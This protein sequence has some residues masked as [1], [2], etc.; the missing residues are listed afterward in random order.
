MPSA[1]QPTVQQ[2]FPL[3]SPTEA[4][5]VS[6]SAQTFA[7]K[8]TLDGGALIKGDTTGNAIASGYVGETVGT[9]RS[10]TGGFTYSVRSNTAVTTSVAN[11]LTQSLDA[12]SYLVSFTTRC[13][14]VSAGSAD[15]VARLRIGGVDVT[16]VIAAV[17]NSVTQT[18]S[19][20][21]PI[22][23]SSNGTVV[24]VA[25]SIASNTSAGNS[26]EMWIVRIA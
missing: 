1:F 18:L 22:V 20:S 24:S 3:A 12:G 11:I 26:H 21:L 13:Y 15:F 14:L 8:K 2:S 25:A 5:M 6:T 17:S 9:L 16:T 23:V 7:G 4:G 19:C 10:G